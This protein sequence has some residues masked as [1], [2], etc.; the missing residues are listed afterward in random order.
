MVHV[1]RVKRTRVRPTETISGRLLRAI[2][3]ITQ[4]LTALPFTRSPARIVGGRLTPD[5]GLVMKISHFKIYGKC[6]Q[7][8]KLD[9]IIYSIFKKNSEII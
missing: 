9:K 3:K 8:F 1:T 2:P 5:H 6:M 4:R 7:I